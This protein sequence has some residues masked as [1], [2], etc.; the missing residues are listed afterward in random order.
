MSLTEII[1]LVKGVFQDTLVR[2]L[3]GILLVAVIIERYTQ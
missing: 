3:L 2:V 1:E